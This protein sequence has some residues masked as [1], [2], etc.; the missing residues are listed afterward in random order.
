MMLPDIMPAL[1]VGNPIAIFTNVMLA[2]GA[3]HVVFRLAAEAAYRAF[4]RLIA[5]HAFLQTCA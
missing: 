4:D 1:D 2:A 3:K 5:D